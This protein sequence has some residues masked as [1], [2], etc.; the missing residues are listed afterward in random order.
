MQLLTSGLS[1]DLAGDATLP[2]AASDV[3]KAREKR[4]LHMFERRVQEMSA[5]SLRMIDAVVE[6]RDARAAVQTP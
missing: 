6:L 3:A 2:A 4:A 1:A 5:A